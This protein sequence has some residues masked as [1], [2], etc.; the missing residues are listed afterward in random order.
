MP[1]DGSTLP[2]AHTVLPGV[3][4]GCHP[5]G[6]DKSNKHPRYCDNEGSRFYRAGRLSP[7]ET[8]LA[9]G[10]EL[11]RVLDD[12]EG[13]FWRKRLR[14]D[15][16]RVRWWHGAIF[17][18]H[19][20]HDGGRFRKERAFFGVM[21][22]TGG[23]RQVEGVAPDAIRHE[24][25]AVCE[26]FNQGV[27]AFNDVSS[28]GILDRTRLVAA[29]YA[30]IL[31]VHPFADGNHRAS[32]VVLSAALWS[33]GLPNVW[34]LGPREMSVHDDSL[35]PALLS[36]SG[37]VEPFAELLAELILHVSDDAK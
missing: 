1:E 13:A 8:W 32:F 5:R 10:D 14:M 33:L 35:V 17:A 15:S 9:L 16:E 12:A 20:P 21:M 19:F 30:G 31:R 27:D 11:A 2:G 6:M 37:D 3:R 36:A 22:P 24:L 25:T 18:R 29:M 4:S 7:E 23:M 28:T 26:S 34:F